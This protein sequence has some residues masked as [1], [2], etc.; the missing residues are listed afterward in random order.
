MKSTLSIILV[1]FG[2]IFVCGC[3]GQMPTKN[4]VLKVFKRDTANERR[5]REYEAKSAYMGKPVANQKYAY[6]VWW[7]GK[8]VKGVP[9][10][11]QGIYDLRW[12][13][14]SS[15]LVFHAQFIWCTQSK[16]FW[17]KDSA[18]QFYKKQC[19][20]STDQWM[21]SVRKVLFDSIQVKDER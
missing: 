2:F 8:L 11:E 17:A 21:K 9:C 3:N 14:G 18:I 6:L 19:I 12:G 20:D 15:C 7:E 5:E 10:P 13:Y 4:N 1:V 16:G